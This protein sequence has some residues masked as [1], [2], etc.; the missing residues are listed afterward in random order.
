MKVLEVKN[1]MQAVQKN[2]SIH[3]DTC[4]EGC[5]V[6]I[7]DFTEEMLDKFFSLY[8]VAIDKAM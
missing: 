3:K 1:V 5:L 2:I 4:G 6:G 7:D 8:Y